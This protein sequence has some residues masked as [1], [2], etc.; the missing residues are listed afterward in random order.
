LDAFTSVDARSRWPSLIL[1][2]L[3]RKPVRS[4]AFLIA[5]FALTLVSCEPD[6]S[7]IS[8]DLQRGDQIVAAVEQYKLDKGRYPDAL[9]ALVP[10]YI[11]A[12]QN[13]RYGKR[14]WE[15]RTYPDGAFGLFVSGSQIY[16]DAYMY[17]S[18]RGK[19]EVAHNDF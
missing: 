16:H 5:F 14:Q 4:T 12:I 9:S 8:E 17:V 1:F 11:S 19:W 15:Y 2:S 3:D 18:R 13:P 10:Q 6:K 7:S